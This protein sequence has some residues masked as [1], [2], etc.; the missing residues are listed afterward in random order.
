[1]DDDRFVV[2]SI[3]ISF[4]LMFVG[5]FYGGADMSDGAVVRLISGVVI[6]V[7]GFLSIQRK[8]VED[9]LRTLNQTL[10]LRVLARTA[11]AEEKSKRLEQQI[12][13]LQKISSDST[14]ESLNK[15]EEVI[16]SLRD[17][18]KYEGH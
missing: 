5:W 1:M 15:L 14:D 13:I 7:A 8:N 6:G 10:E 2:G 18:S 9:K 3:F 12:K 17:I 11:A 4:I 16:K